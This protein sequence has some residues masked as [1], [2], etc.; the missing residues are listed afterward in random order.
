MAD[1]IDIGGLFDCA[2]RALIP[3]TELDYRLPMLVQPGFH[4]AK[5]LLVNEL[6]CGID[7][8]YGCVACSC[9]HFCLPTLKRHRLVIAVAAIVG[10]CPTLESAFNRSLVHFD[11]Q[12]KADGPKTHRR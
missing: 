4:D 11:L 10:K 6:A 2:R 1:S 7:R 12:H 9:L 3:G 5:S 8:L